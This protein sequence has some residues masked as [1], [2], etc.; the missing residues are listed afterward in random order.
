MMQF[1]Q[2]FENEL[3]GVTDFDRAIDILTSTGR[4]LG[5]DGT[6]YIYAPK[7]KEQDGTLCMP[8]VHRISPDLPG[9]SYH[10]ERKEYF[11]FDPIYQ[12]C[13]ETTLPVVWSFS[14]DHQYIQGYKRHFTAVQHQFAQ[15][16]VKMGLRNGI[17]VPLH[18]PRGE[19]AF[20]CFLSSEDKND[21]LERI[22]IESDIIMLMAHHFHEKVSRSLDN[23]VAQT[24]GIAL[25]PREHECLKFAAHGKTNED[26][27]DLL[28][29][30]ERTVR[31]HL[32]NAAQKLGATNR[33]HVVGKAAS[34][35]LIGLVD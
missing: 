21:F 15:E 17:T 2:D 18:L 12:R 16:A 1:V 10:Y 13:L 26:I 9:W 20:V 19:M 29:L 5:F 25:S 14:A 6:A 27:A 22:K 32:V 28:G 31:F 4:A 34:L 30:K 11:R 33:V 7:P 3:C 24:S 8:P 23:W 35:G